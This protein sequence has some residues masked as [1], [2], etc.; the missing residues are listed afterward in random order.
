MSRDQLILAGQLLFGDDWKSAMARALGPL[1]PR[2]ARS[3]I[4][5]RLVRRWASGER[6]VPA[7]V[8]P[9]L[10]GMIEVRMADFGAWMMEGKCNERER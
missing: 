3:S 8:K 4:D 6:D 7:W 10:I 1:H 9:A 5:E 2:G